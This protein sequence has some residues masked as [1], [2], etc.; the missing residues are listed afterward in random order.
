M[1]DRNDLTFFPELARH[2]NRK[3]GLF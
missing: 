1:L 2:G 3:G